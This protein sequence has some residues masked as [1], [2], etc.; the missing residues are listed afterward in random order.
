MNWHDLISNIQP[1][2]AG[3]SSLTFSH[4]PPPPPPK[5]R[6]TTWPKSTAAEQ[7]DFAL[8]LWPRIKSSRFSQQSTVSM[9]IR[10]PVPDSLV[11]GSVAPPYPI[12]PTAASF[13]SEDAPNQLLPDSAV[14]SD[15]VWS[16]E[17][18]THR[19]DGGIPGL[20]KV[21]PPAGYTPKS[22]RDALRPAAASTN[23]FLRKQS[24]GSSASGNESSA[25]AWGGLQGRPEHPSAS[26]ST[27]TYADSSRTH[28]PLITT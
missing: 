5:P 27:S 3:P 21:G 8:W 12:T 15:N 18:H 1:T 23:P 26:S 14:H 20:L 2:L 11:P 28:H 9:V 24:S 4:P 25:N 7:L 17:G 22:S 10:K 6:Q 19:Q 13:P 16:A